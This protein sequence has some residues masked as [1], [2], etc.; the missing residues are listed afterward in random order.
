M[1]PAEKY[2]AARNA[3]QAAWDVYMGEDVDV[4]GAEYAAYKA[5]L[6]ARNAAQLEWPGWEAWMNSVEQLR[7][8]PWN[9]DD[10]VQGG[11]E[12]DKKDLFG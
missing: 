10:L 12:K 1:T 3:V 9:Y 8:K 6:D 7:G 5:A 2:F 11:W 4:A